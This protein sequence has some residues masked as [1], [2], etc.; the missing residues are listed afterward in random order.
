MRRQIVAE[1]E[2]ILTEQG[3]VGFRWTRRW[4]GAETWQW[5]LFARPEG[6][7]TLVRA[8]RLTGEAR[9]RRAM[10]LAA[11]RAVG[12]NPNNLTYCAGL[13]PRYQDWPL[14]EFCVD[15]GRVHPIDE[16]TPDATMGPVPYLWGSLG[17]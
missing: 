12:A 7:V 2:R 15:S 16:F 1:A 8:W 14:T 13:V 17:F 4:P 9:F 6:G 11:Q 5:G 10:V 3:K